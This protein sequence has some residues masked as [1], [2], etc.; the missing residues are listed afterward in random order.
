VAS[1]HALARAY[2]A[3]GQINK[4]VARLEEVVAVESGTLPEDHPD[5][6]ASVLAPENDWEVTG[7]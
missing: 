7:Q 6:L 2:L 1:Q 4:A 3:D 5:R